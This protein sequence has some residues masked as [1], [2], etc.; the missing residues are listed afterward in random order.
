ME[1]PGWLLLGFETTGVLLTVF[2]LYIRMEDPKFDDLK[3]EL[4]PLRVFLGA[5]LGQFIASRAIFI[6]MVLHPWFEQWFGEA[7]FVVWFLGSIIAPL[8]GAAPL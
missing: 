4:A 3:S 1:V 7:F 8:S 5:F 2:L 6:F